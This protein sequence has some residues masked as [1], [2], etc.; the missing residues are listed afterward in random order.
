MSGFRDVV[1]G[2][3]RPIESRL[4]REVNVSVTRN[5]SSTI[6]YVKM[7]KAN[8]NVKHYFVC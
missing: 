5:T 8:D 1:Q 6:L 2:C 3:K 7:S 4:V